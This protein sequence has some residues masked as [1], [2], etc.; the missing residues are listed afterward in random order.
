MILWNIEQIFSPPSMFIHDANFNPQ[1]REVSESFTS[2]PYVEVHT[3]GRNSVVMHANSPSPSAQM[4]ESVDTLSTHMGASLLSRRGS[5]SS[6]ELSQSEASE[7]KDE[8]VAT[9]LR[10]RSLV[11][12]SM[13]SELPEQEQ[14]KNFHC[15]FK[16]HGFELENI[17]SGEKSEEFIVKFK[18]IPKAQKA[19]NLREIIGY[20]LRPKWPKRP[21]TACPREFMVLSNKLT[22][23]AGRSFDWR[24]VSEMSKN[25]IVY[26]DKIMGRRARLV[27]K[28]NG[29]VLG[30]TS[31]FTAK[32]HPLLEQL[33]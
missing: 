18:S 11:L 28:A 2:S 5:L 6:M 13:V 23:R 12:K 8:L 7:V 9:S 19:L 15:V 14:I 21:K 1:R 32:G 3:G 22:V 10:C 24:I 27:N 33:E 26:V 30:W 31:L 29:Q 17:T 4:Q 16:G 20:D 25:D